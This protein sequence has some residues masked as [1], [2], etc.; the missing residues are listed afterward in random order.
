LILYITYNDTPSGIYSSQV[1]DVVKYLRGISNEKVKLLSLISI[2][3]FFFNRKKI[4]SELNDAI[5]LPM[6]PGVQNWKFNAFL[7]CFLKL[8][9]KPKSI[10]GRGVFACN[11]AL[12]AKSKST[13]IIYDGRGAISAEWNEYKVGHPK[14]IKSICQIEKLAVL[15]VDFRIAVS[16]K[17]VQYWNEEFNYDLNNYVVIPCTLNSQ[18]ENLKFNQIENQEI[19]E[20]L[21]FNKDDVVLVYSGSNAGWQS[22]DILNDFLRKQLSNDERCKVLF[23]SNENSQI[24]E[25]KLEFPNRIKVLK[26]DVKLVPKYLMTCDYGLMIREDSITNSV[27]SPVKFA[28]YLA[29]GLKV[30]VSNNLGDY[31]EFVKKNNLGNL[32][33]ETKSIKKVEVDDKGLI[34]DFALINF[35][36]QT[37]IKEYSKIL[38]LT[39]HYNV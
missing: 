39:N 27:A 14:L 36:K 20:E 28:E 13:R 19:R 22:F 18:Y 16:Y 35:T 37:F 32:Y 7:I 8:I 10:I 1:I 3:N 31:S 23:L 15:N 30:I 5:V 11:L 26:V 24:K 12:I 9:Y 34:R 17:L 4:K 25:L 38:N 33:Y 21:N 29:C 2:R 6:F